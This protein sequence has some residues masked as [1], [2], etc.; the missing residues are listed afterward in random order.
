[1]RRG[2]PRVSRQ[3][4]ATRESSSYGTPHQG[5]NRMYR[6]IIAYAI[7]FAIGWIVLNLLMAIPQ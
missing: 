7:G 4:V 3:A 6:K 1:M 2:V 5:G